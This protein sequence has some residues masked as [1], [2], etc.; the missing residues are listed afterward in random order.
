MGKMHLCRHI[1][2]KRTKV[3]LL[4]IA[5]VLE[6]FLLYF[7]TPFQLPSYP[8]KLPGLEVYE[9]PTSS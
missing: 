4:K 8:Q 6:T 3:C 9:K 5:K 2:F 1:F 7:K